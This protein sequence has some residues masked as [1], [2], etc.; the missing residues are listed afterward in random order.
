[1]HYHMIDLGL[2]D[3]IAVITGSSRGIGLASAKLLAENGARVFI[4][5]R[6]KIGLGKAVLEYQ[7]RGIMIDSLAGDVSNEIFVKDF[8]RHVVQKAG[9]IDILINNAGLSGTETIENVET[10]K[11][12]RYIEINFKSV[13]LMCREVIPIMKKQKSG[14]I[15]NI[16]SVSALR[17]TAGVHYAAPK[18]GVISLTKVLAKEVG[19]LNIQ[20]NAIAPGLITTEATMHNYSKEFFEQVAEKAALRR[21]GKP[22][23]VAKAVLFFSSSLS[24]FITGQVLEVSGGSTFP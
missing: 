16:A 17:G 7:K 22:D 14:R 1:M 5:G 19:P 23:D 2:K 10:E 13:F 8:I 20:V 11:W 4:N 18:G 6:N 12:D 3:K 9:G 24:D 21:V 15:I